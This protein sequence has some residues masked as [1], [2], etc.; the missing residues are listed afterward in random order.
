ML[1]VVYAQSMRS[2]LQGI[3]EDLD[4]LKDLNQQAPL[5]RLAFRSLERTL[6]MLVA[7]AIGIAKRLVREKTQIQT[8]EAYGVF[9]RLEE[10]G[11][12]DS[13]ANWRAAIGM[14]NVIV[15]DY[16]NIDRDLIIGVLAEKQY[17]LI[18][19]FCEDQV[20]AALGSDTG[21]QK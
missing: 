4:T 17:E 9:V 10:L 11:L 20:A 8:D 18:L 16:L 21:S 3:R 5:D 7:S 1:D 13:S 15:H 6:Q 19:K 2:H 14:R 12:D